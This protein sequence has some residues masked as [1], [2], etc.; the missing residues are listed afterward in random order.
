MGVVV[1]VIV[2][3]I[4]V[5]EMVE[6]VVVKVVVIRGVV[7]RDVIVTCEDIG[8]DDGKVELVG[9]AAATDVVVI[10]FVIE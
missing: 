2:G 6:V 3:R 4:V 7:T 1:A 10:A 8:V 9:S 5:I